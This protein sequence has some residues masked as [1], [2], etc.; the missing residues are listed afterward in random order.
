M[1]FVITISC[2]FEYF[3][4]FL[5]DIYDELSVMLNKTHTFGLFLYGVVL[6]IIKIDTSIAVGYYWLKEQQRT[7]ARKAVRKLV[8]ENLV[9]TTQIM[10][11]F[12]KE[13]YV[14]TTIKQKQNKN[15]YFITILVR[16]IH[17]KKFKNQLPS[18]ACNYCWNLRTFKHLSS[19]RNQ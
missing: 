19:I 5:I 12:K 14:K 4:T 6:C 11:A 8:W 10:T 18:N 7:Q 17:R 15:N 9:A 1:F 16:Y 3:Y 2:K 13:L